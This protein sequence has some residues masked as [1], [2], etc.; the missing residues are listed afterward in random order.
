MLRLKKPNTTISVHL[1]RLFPLVLVYFVFLFSFFRL[2]VCI[3]PFNDFD[4][5]LSFSFTSFGLFLSLDLISF[6]FPSQ[7][8]QLLVQSRNILV[9]GTLIRKAS[10]VWT[11]DDVGRL[12][13]HAL[14][15]VS[16]LIGCIPLL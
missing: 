4:L 6:H 9:R 12:L 1:L 11:N 5:L 7:F 2:S 8:S 3:F 15:I 14:P 13:F 10:A 16:L